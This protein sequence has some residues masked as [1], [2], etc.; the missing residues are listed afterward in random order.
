MKIMKATDFN[1]HNIK[2]KYNFK[3]STDFLDFLQEQLKIKEQDKIEAQQKLDE[4]DCEFSGVEH[5]INNKEFIEFTKRAR[6]G[7]VKRLERAT[8]GIAAI[9][10]DIDIVKN[11]SNN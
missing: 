8:A 6:A 1:V 7:M 3:S 4:F 2:E 5:E 10:A 11:Q 9:K